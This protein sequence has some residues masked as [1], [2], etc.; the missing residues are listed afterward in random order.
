[1]DDESYFDHLD[2]T[3]LSYSSNVVNWLDEPFGR[4]GHRLISP[5][6]PN[7]F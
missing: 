6:Q 7:Q 5:L 3:F 2:R 1:M 4:L